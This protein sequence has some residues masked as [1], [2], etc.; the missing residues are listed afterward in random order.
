MRRSTATLW[1]TPAQALLSQPRQWLT[2]SQDLSLAP[3]EV[4]TR[5]GAARLEIGQVC[6]GR[7]LAASCWTAVTLNHFTA[8]PRVC[9]TV[10]LKPAIS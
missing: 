10:K 6:Y 7:D 4:V 2:K 8:P 5:I 9:I 3:V 1:T